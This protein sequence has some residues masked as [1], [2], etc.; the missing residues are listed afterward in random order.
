MYTPRALYRAPHLYTPCTLHTH[1]TNTNTQNAHTSYTHHTCTYICHTD[2]SQIYIHTQVWCACTHHRHAALRH[3]RICHARHTTCAH[4]TR[5]THPPHTNL[6]Y[7]MPHTDT[8]CTLLG[9]SVI[10]SQDPLLLLALLCRVET[11]C[12][13]AVSQSP[14]T[15]LPQAPGFTCSV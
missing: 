14:V 15:P 8:R 12:H 7:N 2:T 10:R 1:M 11:H 4:T 3:T 9:P 5:N 13:I 6:T